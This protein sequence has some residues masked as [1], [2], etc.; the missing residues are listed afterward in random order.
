MENRKL[1]VKTLPVVALRDTVIMPGTTGQFDVS[2]RNS[3]AAV[4]KAMKRSENRELLLVLQKDAAVEDPV[5][6]DLAS[7][8]VIAKVIHIV[9]VQEG[10]Y[11]V[12]VEGLAAAA[13]DTVVKDETGLE[14]GID[15][16]KGIWEPLPD[17]PKEHAEDPEEYGMSLA[18]AEASIR[19]LKELTAQYAARN[20]GLSQE[21]LNVLMEIRSLPGFIR[22]LSGV[23]TLTPEQKQSLIDT[24]AVKET[25]E[26]LLEIL[27]T[28]IEIGAAKKDLQEKI[29]GKVDKDQKDYLL[30]EQ[31][32]A[33]REE[34]GETSDEDEEIA[35]LRKRT[36]ELDAPEEIKEAIRGHIKRYEKMPVSS[37][38]SNVLYNY[39]DTLLSMPWNK[40]SEDR[41][42]LAAAKEILE[43]DH[44]GLTDVKER[45]LEFLAVRQLTGQGKSPI[46]CLI[47][48]PGT[49]KTSIGKSIA[50]ALGKEY[51]RVSLGGVHDEAEVR[52]HR[53]TYIG[54]MP[55]RIAAAMKKAGVSN[56]LMVLDEVDKVGSD[57]RGDVASALLEA[58]DS[59]QNSRFV[60]HYIDLP[61]DLSRVLFIATANTSETI[62]PPL[63]DRMEVIRIAG[64]TDQEK[65]HI[66]CDHLIPKVRE[67]NGL[68]A[69]QLSVTKEA[70][71]TI[72]RAYTKE[73]GVRQLER[74]LGE[75]CRKTARQILEN[76]K[77]RVRV[78]DRNVVKLLG[79]PPYRTEKKNDLD[80]IGV[81]RGLAWTA[82]GG[83]TM[84]VEVSTLPGKG[85]L[86]LTGQLGSVMQ[87]SARTGI[88]YVRSVAGR[89]KID[90]EYFQKHD[91]HIHVPEGAVPKDG[92]SAGITMATAIL[93]AVTER[94]VRADLAMTGEIT[95]RGRVLPSGGL[96]EKLLAAKQAGIGTVIVPEDNRANVGDIDAEIT[97]GIK[98]VYAKTMDEVAGTAILGRNV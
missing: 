75:I 22:R 92:P 74:K 84:P 9:K 26:K 15:Q 82:V 52:G 5:Q 23:L 20:A 11:R 37:P 10:F 54:A 28:E 51:V 78:T 63:L 83:T 93:S 18:E 19:L 32:R 38:D 49:G 53:R 60:D 59:E 62:P 8:G 85:E 97:D 16:V 30:R 69:G 73:A 68:T 96:K 80:E 64:Y 89:Y 66:A 41:C 56:P 45:V 47:G 98:I 39:L 94:P 2:R 12:M 35:E 50:E 40:T 67:N 34:L 76:G 21:V 14:A 7:V 81:V 65:I 3:V 44:Y 88:S 70:V 95:L 6:S 42:D 72:I 31:L 87:E 17:L 48:P 86:V 33:I 29:R 79:T 13:V 90:Q 43:R 1:L 91:L 4:E 58:L 77:K 36:E 61:L 25:A 57:H 24:P 71:E 27:H 55:G 46:L